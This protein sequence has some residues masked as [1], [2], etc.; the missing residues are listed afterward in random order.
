MIMKKTCKLIKVLILLL[1]VTCLFLFN[2]GCGL[3]TV[4][5][6]DSPHLIV[7]SPEAQNESQDTKYFEFYTNE[8]TNIEGFTFQGTEVY[9]KIY[10]S[11]SQM[12]SETSVLQTLS[13]DTDKSATAA[14]KMINNTSSG[15][16]GYK[17]LKVAGNQTSP[18]IPDSGSNERVYIRL[19]D[20]QNV[21]DYSAKILVNGQYLN[22]SVSKTVPVRNTADR[23]T[24]NFG[25]NGSLDIV[26]TSVDDDV[27]Y[28]SGVSS[29][30]WYVAMFAAGIGID[31]SYQNYYSNI[32]YLGS[33]SIDA[34]RYDN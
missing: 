5:V 27:K 12:T 1:P 28:S 4:Y 17:A 16:Y 18:L 8:S 6:L 32:L 29:S 33:V 14:D 20:Y 30:T 7:H 2:S 31:A 34:S 26:P 11:Y 3:D 22:G 23:R 10:N 13:N 24:F 21:E 15:G 19:T 9:Y 25:R